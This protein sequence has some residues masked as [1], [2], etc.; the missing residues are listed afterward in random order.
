MAATTRVRTERAEVSLSDFEKEVFALSADTESHNWLIYGDSNCGK[1]SV[2]GTCPGKVFWLVCENGYKTASR[3]G[4]HGHGHVISDTATAWTAVDWLEAK[5]RRSGK[6]RYE[7]LDWVV[8]DGLST[9]EKRFRLGYTQEAFDKSG[10]TKRAH[11][12]LPDKP[13]YFNTQNFLISWLPRLVDMPVNLLI[14]A[15]AYRTGADD[16]ELMVYPGVQGKGGETANAISGLMDITGYMEARQLR[17]RDTDETKLV[18]RLWLESPTRK[19]RDKD[20]MRYVCGEKY[21]NLGRYIDFPT[22]PSILD[23]I[24]GE[25][26]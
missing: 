13:D 19:T 3:R 6:R 17:I 22:V 8:L 12:N 24:N 14:T 9:M 11:R 25:E 21:G 23:K 1:T 18:R 2:A 10:G 20:N 7:M 16:G 26:R 5:S 4:A 15:H